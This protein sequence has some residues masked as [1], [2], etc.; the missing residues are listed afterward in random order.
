ML[1]NCGPPTIRRLLGDLRFRCPGVPRTC[2]SCTSGNNSHA[3]K[4]GH[5][6]DWIKAKFYRRKLYYR[7]GTHIHFINL[8]SITFT[9]FKLKKKKVGFKPNF[10]KALLPRILLNEIATFLLSKNPIL[11]PTKPNELWDS[12]IVEHVWQQS[13]LNITLA[14]TFYLWDFLEHMINPRWFVTLIPLPFSSP[15]VI[16]RLKHI[17]VSLPFSKW[18]EKW[19]SNPTFF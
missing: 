3:P 7:R 6:P 4:A 9:F 17:Q 2:N 18:K 12:Y 13:V 15:N 10:S 14:P 16:S 5:M 8:F 1:R 19:A 11:V